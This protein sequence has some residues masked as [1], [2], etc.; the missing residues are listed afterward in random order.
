MPVM[1]NLLCD[2]KLPKIVVFWQYGKLYFQ[3]AGRIFPLKCL[4]TSAGHN[5]SQTLNERDY[6][7]LLRLMGLQDR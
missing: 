5:E 3:I 4:T 1:I 6:K 2:C 7:C